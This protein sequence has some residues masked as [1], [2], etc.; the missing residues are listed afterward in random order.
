[1][2]YLC[3]QTLNHLGRKQKREHIT[4]SYKFVSSNRQLTLADEKVCLFE[5]DDV[6]ALKRN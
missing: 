3:Q 5:Q 1:M 6:A 4:S 2:K